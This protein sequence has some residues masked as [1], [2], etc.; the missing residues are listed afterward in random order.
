MLSRV[1]KPRELTLVRLGEV[2][3]NGRLPCSSAPL[4]EFFDDRQ[5]CRLW[6]IAP[7]M[8]SALVDDFAHANRRGAAKLVVRLM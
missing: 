5:R 7:S 3:V 8:K 1:R 2:C 4:A 6:S